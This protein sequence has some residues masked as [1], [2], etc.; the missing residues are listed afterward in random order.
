MTWRDELPPSDDENDP[1]YREDSADDSEDELPWSVA[2]D[3]AEWVVQYSDEITQL[4]AALKTAGVSL[5]GN[6]FLQMP[7]A[8][9]G[10]A[11][12]LYKY[13]SPGALTSSD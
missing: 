12:M 5:F 9:T 6:A 10:F 8:S 13:T 2:R 4:F 11:H 7:G 1:D 3:R